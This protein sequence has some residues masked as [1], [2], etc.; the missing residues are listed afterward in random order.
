MEDE[1]QQS[2]EEELANRFVHV[3]ELPSLPTVP[4]IDVKLP[5]HPDVTKKKQGNQL[6]G[7]AKN[8]IAL[9]AATSFIAPIIVFA[10]IG[11][12]ADHRFNGHSMIIF[13]AIVV[14][15]ILGVVS[16]LNVMKRL[17]D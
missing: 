10:V 5:E 1:N 14:G 13:A 8:G 7:M 15:L 6:S 2:T 17:A 3:Q 16:L 12:Y 11:N 4:K 9:T